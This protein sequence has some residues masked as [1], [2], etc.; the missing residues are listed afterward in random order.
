MPL[1]DKNRASP[2]SAGWLTL[3]KFSVVS[4]VLFSF[5]F[6]SLASA[7]TADLNTLTKKVDALEANQKSL[8]DE[9]EGLRKL[10]ASRLSPV[11]SPVNLKIE[12]DQFKGDPKARVSLI[13]FFDYQCP[14]CKIHFNQTLPKLITDYIRTGKIKYFVRDFPLHADALKAAEA[15]QCADDQGKFWLLH[16]QLIVNSDSLGRKNLS[17]LAQNLALDVV[18]FDKCLDSNKYSEKIHEGMSE[19]ERAGVAG[20]PTFFLGIADEHDHLLKSAQ[21]FDGLV[22]YTLLK[23]AIDSLVAQQK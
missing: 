9:L 8:R 18:I 21:R 11:S 19:G 13:E 12:G 23:S 14:Y 4:A 17:L 20:T 22:P 3:R 6:L 7:Q 5:L 16:D 2:K 10:L 15:A 1:N